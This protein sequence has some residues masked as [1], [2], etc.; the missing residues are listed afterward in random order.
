MKT[1]RIFLAVASVSFLAAIGLGVGLS[2]PRLAHADGTTSDGLGTWEGTG[3]TTEVDGKVVGPFTIV[4]TRTA[5]ANGTGVRADGKIHTADGKDIVFWQ[6][7]AQRGGGK[8]KVTS[9]LGAG[10]GACF[11]N[12][13]CQSLEQR[14]DGHAFASTVAKD[15]ADKVRVLVTELEHGRA[16]RF[17]AQT[18]VKKP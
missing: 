18:L 5:L 3:V 12:G 15:S 9:N 17:Y 7:T 1:N 6:E 4:V 13:M 8:F 11:A 10:G 16:V 14:D 2:G